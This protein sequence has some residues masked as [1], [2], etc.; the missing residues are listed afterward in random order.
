MLTPEANFPPGLLIPVANH[1]FIRI[2][3]TGGKFTTGF[4][5]NGGKFSTVVVNT[6]GK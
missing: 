2:F 1:L 6:G 5:E 3:D 4:N